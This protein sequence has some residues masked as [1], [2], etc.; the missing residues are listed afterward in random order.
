MAQAAIK[1][2][3]TDESGTS[4]KAAGS[5]D[6]Q[7]S[8]R[9][10]KL[11]SAFQ[12]LESDIHGLTHMASLVSMAI[13]QT[14]NYDPTILTGNRDFYYISHD[15]VKMVMWSAHHLENLTEQLQA[16]YRDGYKGATC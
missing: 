6:P 5:A 14:L 12:D 11:A 3:T 2:I 9:E 16:K 7:M 13:E 4:S 10:A 1:L 8:A 15:T